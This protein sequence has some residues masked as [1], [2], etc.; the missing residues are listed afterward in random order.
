M[1]GKR[2]PGTI[3]QLPH[4]YYFDKI[5]LDNVLGTSGFNIVSG[6]DNIEEFHKNTG[7]NSKVN[8]YPTS[9]DVIIDIC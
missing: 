3:V 7:Q 8:M 9:V 4:N 2:D 6:N 1:E 5:T